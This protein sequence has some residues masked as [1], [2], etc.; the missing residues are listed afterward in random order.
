M[1]NSDR[2]VE[3]NQ[4]FGSWTVIRLA[5]KEEKN[6]SSRHLSYLCRCQCGAEKVVQLRHLLNGKSTKCSRWCPLVPRKEKPKRGNGPRY[7]GLSSAGSRKFGTIRPY[8]IWCGMKRRNV[9]CSEWID[10]FP[11]FLEY[12]LEVGGFQLSDFQGPNVPWSYHKVTR[13]DEGKPYGPGNLLVVAFRTE[14]AWHTPTYQYWMKLARQGILDDA[15]T[16]S[17]VLFL[18][19]FGIKERGYLLRRKDIT[20]YHSLRN[21]EWI[22]SRQ[23]DTT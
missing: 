17:Y 3:P 19:T 12:Y 15:M 14:R 5:T 8:D 23:K 6:H 1:Q 18:N 4:V 13:P 2:P 22:R 7:S 10:D 9:L 11:S 21:S 20:Q 16:A